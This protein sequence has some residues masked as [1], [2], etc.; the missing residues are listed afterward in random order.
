MSDLAVIAQ[1]GALDQYA[2]A[3]EFVVLS[4]E[5][6][7]EWLTGCIAHGDIDTIVEIKSQAEAVRVYT[8]TRQLGRDAELAAA[9]IVRRAERG[10]GLCIRKGQESGDVR[11]SA[12]H[13]V[14]DANSMSPSG[15]AQAAKATLSSYY[16]MTDGVSDE[17]FDEAVAEAK[18]ENNLSRNNVVRKVDAKRVLD[19]DKRDGNTVAARV[20]LA[21][22]MAV[23]GSTSDQIADAIGITRR[24]MST[25]RK[26][27]GIDVPADTVAGRNH[28][29]NAE[30]IIN[31]SV[32]LLEGIASGL[33]LIEDVSSLDAEKRQEWLEALTLPLSAINRFKKELAR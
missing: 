30:R 20:A 4:C 31:E 2:D 12:K 32:A 14:H 17:V 33:A 6:A 24:S 25:F 16:D 15:V 7:K 5:R 3:G 27:H 10:I 29:V 13:G 11:R 26:R 8:T 22:E 23:K 1:P 28:R 21:K 18:A 19:S 9:E